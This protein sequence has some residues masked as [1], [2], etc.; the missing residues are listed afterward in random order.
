ML[1]PL[2]IGPA[3]ITAVSSGVGY[4]TAL[5]F[6]AAGFET[7][8]HCAQFHQLVDLRA[9]GCQILTLD[10]TD[11]AARCAAVEAVEKQ[12]GA[13]GILVNNAGYGQYGPP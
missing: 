10:V 3:L 9:A 6:R 13:V 5:T 11:E 4:A 7:F 12:F 2:D 1:K 8:G